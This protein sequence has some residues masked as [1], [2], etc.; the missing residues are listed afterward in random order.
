[1]T[2]KRRN[3]PTRDGV[4]ADVVA[5]AVEIT[6]KQRTV[7]FAICMACGIQAY[8]D[9]KIETGHEPTTLSL[10]ERDAVAEVHK[11]TDRKE[12]EGWSKFRRL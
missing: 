9:H 10:A 1:M 4:R 7:P 11:E 8:S 5:R 6:A 3:E 2:A 12:A